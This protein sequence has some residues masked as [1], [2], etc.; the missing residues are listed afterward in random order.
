MK[1]VLLEVGRGIFFLWNSINQ[2][3]RWV[4][5]IHGRCIDPR[6]LRQFH[7]WMRW[8]PYCTSTPL[9]SS[10]PIFLDAITHLYKRSC[11]SVR[12]SVCRSVGPSVSRSRV[13]FE[14]R[15]TRFLDATMH[16]YKRSCRS[17]RPS[18]RPSVPHY[19][20]TL[21]IKIFECGK[22][23][24][25]KK[26]MIQ[27]VTTRKSYLTYVPPRYL[28]MSKRIFISFKLFF[29]MVGDSTQLW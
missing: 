12:P 21:K 28:L 4:G 25:V 15:K 24:N 14:R 26:K 22:S 9:L 5:T 27:W 6:L 29:L 1:A 3:V 17:V 8:I 18:V 19:F 23:S 16:L 20:Q 10:V 7:N 2:L 13:I 11:P